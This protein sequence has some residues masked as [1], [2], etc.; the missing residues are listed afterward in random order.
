MREGDTIVQ[1]V[2]LPPIRAFSQKLIFGVRIKEIID[3]SDE[4]GFSYE[5]LEG[6]VEKGISTFTVGHAGSGLLFRIHTLSAPGNPLSRLLGPVFSVPYQAYCT[7]QA[8][9]NVRKTAIS[10]QLIE[11]PHQK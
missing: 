1:Q 5:T 6:H 9:R 10:G 11:D 3:R 4:A 7:R 2:H 8:L